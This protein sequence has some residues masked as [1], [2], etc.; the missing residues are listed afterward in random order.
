MLQARLAQAHIFQSDRGQHMNGLIRMNITALP[1][2]LKIP[3]LTAFAT[4]YLAVS[5]M[6][7]SPL[8]VSVP[9]D[10]D[11]LSAAPSE[12]QLNFRGAAKLVKLSLSQDGTDIPIGD[13][14]LMQMATRHVVALPA[15]SAGS[16]KVR[17]R[18][19]SADGHVIRGDFDFTVG[20]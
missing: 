1:R 11:I 20:E 4:L 10:G 18:A 19:L 3:L 15:M 12:L 5:A 8:S 14:H 17:W 7:H 9:A 16:F 13:A 6:A 2:H